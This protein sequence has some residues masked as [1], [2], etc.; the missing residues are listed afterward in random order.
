MDIDALSTCRIHLTQLSVKSLRTLLLQLGCDLRPDLRVAL[1]SPAE[2]VEEVLEIEGCSS[3][4]HRNVAKAVDS[5]HSLIR[6][7]DKHA[8]SEL[9]PG[10]KDVHKMMRNL[11]HQLRRRF[12]GP[13][14]QVSVHL[15]RV[16]IHNLIT[17]REKP[18]DQS[19][20]TAG[21]R[22]KDKD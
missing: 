5:V 20:L 15:D 21:C 17:C 16:R 1:R 18:L 2:A 8:G 7:L 10:L 11:F 4:Q 19:S 14:I 3:C 22:A 12:S 13:D 9:L 6:K